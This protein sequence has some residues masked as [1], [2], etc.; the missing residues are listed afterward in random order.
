MSNGKKM[1]DGKITQED[2]Y[3]ENIYKIKLELIKKTTRSEILWK[4]R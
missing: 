3:L 1:K 2:H 4:R